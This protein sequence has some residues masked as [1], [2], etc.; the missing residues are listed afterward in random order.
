MVVAMHCVVARIAPRLARARITPS[1][2]PTARVPTE[3]GFTGV[4]GRVAGAA[5]ALSWTAAPHQASSRTA[6]LR[7]RVSHRAHPRAALASPLTRASAEGPAAGAAA[8]ISTSANV[9]YGKPAPGVN[10]THQLITFFR[11]T[12]LKDPDA[13]VEAH[14]AYVAEHNL[15]IRGRIY[16]NEQGINAQMSGKGVDGETYARWVESRPGFKGMR[17]SVYP[18]DAHGHPK[19]SL[20][21]KP[22]SLIHI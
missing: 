18:T 19:L 8:S 2:V 20:R 7:A 6:L 21:Y 1:S 15:Q 10:V 16:I 9:C 5:R 4:G 17:I 14:H 11:F 13:E 22:L 12:E 3:K